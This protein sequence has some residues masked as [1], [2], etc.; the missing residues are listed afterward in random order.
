MAAGLAAALA[1]ALGAPAARAEDHRAYVDSKPEDCRD[2]HRGAGVPDNH[3][4][5]F[6]KDHRLL[7]EKASN[8]CLQCH[9]LSYCLDCHKGGAVEP[10]PRSSLSRRG[11]PMPRSHAAD[12]ISTHP[13]KARDDPQ[14]CLRC[15]ESARFC[16]DCHLRQSRF[17]LA[18]RPHS[19][20]FVAP[21]VPDPVWVSQH[22][23]E[24]R[25][26]LQTCQGCHPQK[27]DCSNV[28][29]HAGLGGR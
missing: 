10:D 15:H 18:M 19:P 24:A 2:C 28:A 9:Q 17:P 6:K 16:S 21:G 1:L 26:S 3:G 8:N 4:A 13:L 12:F 29:C 7:A 25:R 14:S 27:S 20:T 23:A 11:E 22:K 5:S